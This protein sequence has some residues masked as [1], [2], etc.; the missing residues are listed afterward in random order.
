MLG[1]QKLN[2]NFGPLSLDSGSRATSS[3]CPWPPVDFSW[4]VTRVLREGGCWAQLAGFQA[5]SLRNAGFASSRALIA[6]DTLCFP[7]CGGAGSRRP[8][9]LPQIRE[10]TCLV[11]SYPRETDFA[12]G[13]G[14]PYGSLDYS[15]CWRLST[16]RAGFLAIANSPGRV[17]H[18]ICEHSIQ[19]Q[20][21]G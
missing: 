11:S 9:S 10:L 16:E 7:V 15:D 20:L 2:D 21:D 12:T 14:E 19:D 18:T 6:L 1:K 3:V 17:A 8:P 4:G 5:R 13:L